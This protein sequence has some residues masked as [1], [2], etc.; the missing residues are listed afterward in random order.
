M[1]SHL[2]RTH[3]TVCLQPPP[4]NGPGKP[5]VFLHGV[6]ADRVYRV[7]QLP[8]RLVSSYL[9]FPPLPVKPAVYLCC[10][11]PGVASGGRYPLSCPAQP[12][13]SSQTTF[14]SACAAVYF[15]RCP[16]IPTF[17]VS[18]KCFS[19]F[20]PFILHFSPRKT[21]FFGMII[22]SEIRTRFSNCP[23]STGTSAAPTGFFSP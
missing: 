4:R 16:I 12:G 23:K 6:A 2:S 21:A 10:T 8:E 18:V 5:Y 22:R 9:A 11:F 19:C 14:R 15:T 3:V 7:P 20:I 17:C 1:N 13:L